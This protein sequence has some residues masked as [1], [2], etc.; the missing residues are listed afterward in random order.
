MRLSLLTSAAGLCAPLTASW[1]A[2]AAIS[3]SIRSDFRP[4]STFQIFESLGYSK[5]MGVYEIT[6]PYNTFDPITCHHLTP[7]Q[8]PIQRMR[9][10]HR[11]ICLPT[12]TTLT[13]RYAMLIRPFYP[14]L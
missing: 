6:P 14:L 11:R 1:S 8:H 5:L 2:I 12:D 7:S 4:R 3:V 13:S 9:R 10:F